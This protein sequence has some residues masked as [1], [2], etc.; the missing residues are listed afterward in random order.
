MRGDFVRCLKRNQRT[1]LYLPYLQTDAVLDDD[2]R[3]TGEEAPDYAPP[4]EKK[5]NIS[6]ADQAAYVQIFG[7]FTDYTHILVMDDPNVEIDENGLIVWKGNTYIVQRV[8]PSINSVRIALKKVTI[9]VP[10]DY[11]HA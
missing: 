4:V 6:P 1:F 3:E 11:L 8:A 9:N 5:G 2:E 7:T 10:T